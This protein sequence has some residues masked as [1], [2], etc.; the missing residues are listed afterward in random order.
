MNNDDRYLKF[1]KAIT[2]ILKYIAEISAVLLAGLASIL[3]FLNVW[4]TDILLS[5]FLA[6]F[7]FILPLYL[8]Q[9]HELKELKIKM[10]NSF[11][12]VEKLV[13]DKFNPSCDMV[14]YKK[15]EPKEIEVIKSAKEELFFLQETGNLLVERNK[16]DIFNFLKEGGILKIVVCSQDINTTQLLAF[17]N[18]DLTEPSNFV[19]RQNNFIAQIKS[20][21]NSAE[22]SKNIFK[23]NIEIRYLPYPIGIT[24]VLCNE[25]NRAHGVVRFSDF[26]AQYTDKIDIYI[27]QSLE[28]QTF[29]HYSNQLKNYYLHS[30]KKILITGDPHQGKTTLIK[31]LIEKTDSSL[32]SQ[33]VY[34]V[35]SEEI[36]ENGK[37][38]GY[39]YYTSSSSKPVV[40]ATLNTEGDSKYTYNIPELDNLA[41]E[42]SRNIDKILI[43]DEI[44]VMQL[45]SSNYKK[46]IQE[47]LDKH[48]ITLIGT[49][50][51]NVASDSDI[52]KIKINVFTDCIE[53][54]RD[55]HDEILHRLDK[56]L[57]ASIN[58]YSTLRKKD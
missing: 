2:K 40:F 50:T 51:K 53:F 41:N 16:V 58:L 35:C 27:N 23:E 44:G 36:M 15:N 19:L 55:K 24:A 28:P 56:E 14:F 1:Y 38:I 12:K 26:K 47:I 7:T 5:V 13:D 18:S 30:Y 52:G 10:D 46:I 22:K 25:K 33:Y 8:L 39:Q 34:Y 3:G 43:I 17:R 6:L 32:L 45:E 48:N 11:T 29:A 57:Q 54:S 20:I 37:R 42:I 31:E 9:K 21:Y 4:D 49:I